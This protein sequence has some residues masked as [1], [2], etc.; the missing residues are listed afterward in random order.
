MPQDERSVELGQRFR[1]AQVA[2]RDARKTLEKRK[3]EQGDEPQWLI[4]EYEAAERRFEEAATE[5]SEHLATT[6]R[7]IVRR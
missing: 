4:D 1:E 7:K 2:V 3:T 5:W 6:G